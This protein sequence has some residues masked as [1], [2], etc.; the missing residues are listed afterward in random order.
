MTPNVPDGFGA[1]LRR[2]REQRRMTQRELADASGTHVTHLSRLEGNQRAEVSREL[3]ERLGNSLG[4]RAELAAAAERLT[5]QTERAISGYAEALDDTVFERQ[6]LPALR[7]IA[8]GVRASQLLA[9]TPGGAVRGGR[10]DPGAICRILGFAVVTRVAN[11]G[12]PVEFSG[13][14]ITVSDPGLQGDPAA[15]PRIRFL[16]AHA[17]AHASTSS[18]PQRTPQPAQTMDDDP[19]CSYPRMQP[20]EDMACDIAAHLLCPVNL[21]EPAFHEAL[22]DVMVDGGEATEESD[23]GGPPAPTDIPWR[24]D[25]GQIVSA[26]AQKLAIPGWVALRRLADEALLDDEAPYYTSGERP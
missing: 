4:A 26:V 21:L 5:P 10:I 15:L 20:G 6:A 25:V 16:I 24:A 13:R 1:T 2:L 11:P 19:R 8:A 18:P 3:L 7:R 23:E 14:T 17:A 9:R 22:R 12:A